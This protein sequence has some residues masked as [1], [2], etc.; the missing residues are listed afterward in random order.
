MKKLLLTALLVMGAL[1]YGRDFEYREKRDIQG[2]WAKHEKRVGRSN[3]KEKEAEGKLKSNN[4]E[5]D[6]TFHRELEKTERGHE[7]K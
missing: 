2:S 6:L 1:S 4:F 3:L 7:G 5:G